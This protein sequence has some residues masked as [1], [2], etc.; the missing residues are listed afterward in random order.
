MNRLSSTFLYLAAAAA[1]AIS[2]CGGV[3]AYV[4]QT[5]GSAY[6]PIRPEEVSVYAGDIA[7]N[8]WVVGPVTV[9]VVGD[10]NAAL[11]ELKKTAAAIGA[12]AVLHL[13]LTKITGFTNRTGLQGMAVRTKP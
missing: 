9:D 3:K 12:D 13:R 6:K 1:L 8:R 4:V 11:E 10:A 5:G 2:G 7:G